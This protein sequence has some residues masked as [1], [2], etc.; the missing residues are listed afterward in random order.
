MSAKTIYHLIAKNC[1]IQYI[2]L[3]KNSGH[4]GIVADSLNCRITDTKVERIIT[5]RIFEDRY[6]K[7]V[8]E[9]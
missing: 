9:I 5:M 3:V 4:F 1:L 7:I 8:L 2:L 6:Q